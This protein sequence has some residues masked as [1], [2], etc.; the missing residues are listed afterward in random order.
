MA[1]L[2]TTPANRSFLSNNKFDFVL[3]RIPNFTYFV[4]AV[5]LP[6]LSL[7]STTVNT[8]FS[9][10]SV[11]GN[12]I[13]FGTLSLT[14]IVDEDM[15]SWYEL[16]SWIFKL[17]NPKGFDKRGG[18][19]DDDELINSV[20]SDATLFIKTNANNPNFKIELYGAYPT[21]LGDMQF[22]SVDN[23]EFITSTA[24]FNYT[25]YEATNI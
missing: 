16:Y 9:A 6:S 3:R 20:T 2:T 17:G 7:Q 10:L 22:S 18:L 23:Q 24:T 11:P 12:Q 4:Q 5:N 21:E 13:S 19:K 15:Q 25:Y 14:F 1:T 8:P